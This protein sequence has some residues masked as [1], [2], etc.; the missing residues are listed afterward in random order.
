VSRRRRKQPFV[1][2]YCAYAP[3]QAPCK[4]EFENGAAIKPRITLCSCSC[5]GDYEERLAAAGQ[6]P[7]EEEIEE[8]DDE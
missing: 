3:H 7:R 2:G 4:G 8:D 1:S 5:H 6:T